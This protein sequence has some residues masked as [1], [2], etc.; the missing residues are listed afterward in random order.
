M[1]AKVRGKPYYEWIPTLDVLRRDGRDEEALELLNECIAAAE[2]DHRSTGGGL[3]PAYT[4]RAAIIH[5]KRGDLDAEVAV[6][7]RFM[8]SARAGFGN[9][10]VEDRLHAARELRMRRRR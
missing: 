1:G 2:R 3:A 7:E 5:R 6:L 9:N 4:L 8:K 10:R